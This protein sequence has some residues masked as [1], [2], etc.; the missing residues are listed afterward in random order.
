MTPCVYLPHCLLG[1]VRTR[2]LGD[3]A[4]NNQFWEITCDRNRRLTHCE[5]CEFKTYCG[6]CLA[7]ADAYYGVLNAGD[8]GCLFNEK[9]WE[10][11]MEQRA[12]GTA[13]PDSPEAERLV[14]SA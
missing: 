2:A 4:R 3:I 11:L 13:E 14:H 7:R 5:V 10:R 12:V 8:P 6:G 9:H 1:N